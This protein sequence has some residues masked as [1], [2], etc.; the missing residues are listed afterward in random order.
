[1]VQLAPQDGLEGAQGV[2]Q[3]HEAALQPGE[4]LSHGEGLGEELLHPA[5]PL[6]RLLVVLA[7][8]LHAQ[9]GDDVLELPV[10][11]QELLHRPGDLVVA[12]PHH[13]GLQNPGGGL[14]GVHGGVDAL[15][16]GR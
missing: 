15:L 11:L 5:G 12:L 1:M 3:L 8:L 2:L 16:R 10:A 13:V 7:E 6:H 14:Q 9:D 4:G